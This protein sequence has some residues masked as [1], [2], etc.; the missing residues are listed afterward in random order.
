[1]NLKKTLILGILIW[2]IF[3]QTTVA[4]EK[5]EREFRISPQEVPTKAI[6]D[7]SKIT[8]K[9]PLKWYKEIGIKDTTY[10]AKG[11]WK[12]KNV[13]IE[14][15]ATGTLEDVEIIEKLRALPA[16]TRNQINQVIKNDGSRFKIKK[17]QLQ[18]I[19]TPQ[20]EL[21]DL[22]SQIDSGTLKPNYEIIANLKV[23]NVYKVFEYLFDNRGKLLQRREV[24]ERSSFNIQF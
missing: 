8:L 6:E 13:S 15:D 7:V 18:Y 12:G 9:K 20:I 23:D 11:T 14:F 19:A 1:M 2:W 3:A 24:V 17:M 5:V 10:E 22:L 16:E 4:Q 21:Q